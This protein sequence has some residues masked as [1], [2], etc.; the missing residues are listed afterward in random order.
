MSNKTFT[1]DYSLYVYEGSG[2]VVVG[3]T[4][5]EALDYIS[6]IS[7]DY[8]TGHFEMF[9]LSPGSYVALA[10]SKGYITNFQ[11]FYVTSTI[12]SMNPFPMV[13]K[14]SEGQIALVLTWGQNEVQD[15]DLHV[16]FE[17]QS[18]ILC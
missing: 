7:G 6:S 9:D 14:L 17:A 3:K 10:Q 2:N 11:R 15:L 5:Y 13:P 18:D 4:A 8:Y 12:V 16:K 1:K